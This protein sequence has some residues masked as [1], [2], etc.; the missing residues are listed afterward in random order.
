MAL[1]KGYLGGFFCWGE[2]T[3]WGTAVTPTQKLKLRRGGDG[4]ETTQDEIFS[5]EIPNVYTDD[6]EA[7]IGNKTVGGPLTF[8]CQYEGHEVIY[9][10]AL[11]NLVSSQPDVTSDE[12]TWLHTYKISDA[13]PDAAGTEKGLTLEIDRDT[14]EF[15][16]EGCKIASI[17]WSIDV[18]GLL[19]CTINISAEDAAFTT[20]P[21]GALTYPTAAYVKYSDAPSGGYVVLYNSAELKCTNLTWTLNNNLDVDRRYLGTNLISEQVRAS[22]VEVTG[23]MTIDFDSTDEYD[24]FI[25]HEARALVIEFNGA[26]INLNF[27]YTE[28]FVFDAVRMISGTP[29]VND[30]GRVTIDASWKAFATDTSNR[31]MEIIQYNTVDNSYDT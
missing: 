19:V 13:L 26:T 10:H 31:E 2:E 18:N 5:E 9:K 30:E 12:D 25:A 17:E 7:V 8:A 4:V 1:A 24:D 6:S 11:G 16:C 3:T 29:R 28:Q 22:K 21:T 14:H 20:A 23:S 27:V 15:L